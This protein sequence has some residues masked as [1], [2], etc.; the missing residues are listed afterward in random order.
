MLRCPTK[1]KESIWSLGPWKYAQGDNWSQVWLFLSPQSRGKILC[2]LLYIDKEDGVWVSKPKL[3]T[4]DEQELIETAKERAALGIG[5]S[6]Y[7]FMRAA[8]AMAKAINVPFK[9]KNPSEMWWRRL[10]KKD[11]LAFLWGPQKQ[12][13]QIGMFLWQRRGS[14]IFFL[15]ERKQFTARAHLEHGRDRAHKAHKPGKVVAEK[16]GKNSSCQM[17]HSATTCH[18]NRLRKCKG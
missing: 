2:P 7:N 13:L 12:L 6:K 17:F 11:T 10:K 3:S 18:C 8:S 1:K 14:V 4:K 16:G 9:N 15:A 5:Y